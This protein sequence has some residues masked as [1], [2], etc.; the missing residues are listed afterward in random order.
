MSSGEASSKVSQAWSNDGSSKNVDLPEIITAP[1]EAS[2]VT[3]IVS[4]D[5]KRVEEEEKKEEQEEEEDESTL[6]GT[7]MF[8]MKTQ[9]H[10]ERTNSTAS[11]DAAAM[12]EKRSGVDAETMENSTKQLMTSM[13][14][15]RIGWKRE[16]STGVK[17]V[18]K[19]YGILI[20]Y[21]LIYLFTLFPLEK[22]T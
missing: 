5:D 10:T 4:S 8:G 11:I 17:K 3:L 14:L 13:D 1:P 12:E 15:E 20:H 21:R 9:D 22:I 16:N 6:M 2:S 7:T 18:R 19:D